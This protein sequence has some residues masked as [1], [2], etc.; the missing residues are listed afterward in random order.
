[1]DV[2]RAKVATPSIIISAPITFPRGVSGYTFSP[3]VVI[4][5]TAHHIVAEYKTPAHALYRVVR[6]IASSIIISKS[7]TDILEEEN[8]TYVFYEMANSYN[9]S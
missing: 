3:M 9:A 6:F 2:G 1:M 5:S 4:V 8:A 7:V